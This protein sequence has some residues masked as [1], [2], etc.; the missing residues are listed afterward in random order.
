MANKQLPR[1]SSSKFYVWGEDLNPEEVTELVGARPDFAWRKGDARAVSVPTRHNKAPIESHRLGCWC[2]AID[3]RRRRHDLSKQLQYWY[4]HLSTRQGQLS[5]LAR[6]GYDMY[7]DCF[8]NEGP[9]FAVELTS[10]LLAGLGSLG[11]G[12]KLSFYDSDELFSE[13]S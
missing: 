4:T 8:I 7:I 1:Y 11:I 10:A 12:I 3:A 6:R 13:R 2:R 9:I 5:K